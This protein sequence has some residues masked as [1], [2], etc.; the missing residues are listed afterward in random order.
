VV[1]DEGRIVQR[2]SYD[3]LMDQPEGLFHR[4]ARR[5]L[6]SEPDRAGTAVEDRQSDGQPATS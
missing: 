6:L 5:Q 2:G 3:E 1:L 4:L